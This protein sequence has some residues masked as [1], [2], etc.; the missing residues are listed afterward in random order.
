MRPI[1]TKADRTAAL[2]FA[3]RHDWGRRAYLDGDHL[4]G[5]EDVYTKGGELFVTEA[6]IT[7]TVQAARAFGE[8]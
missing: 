4:A 7:A 3:K 6:R 8:Y 1:I 2:R 5:L